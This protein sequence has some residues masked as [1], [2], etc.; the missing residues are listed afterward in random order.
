MYL[1]DSISH[2]TMA[3]SIRLRATLHAIDDDRF[4]CGKCDPA[5]RKSK[6]CETSSQN[7]VHVLEDDL[8]FKRCPGNYFSHE[9]MNFLEM[10]EQFETTGTL[11]YPG[12]LVE[13]PNKIMD[14]F[15]TIACHKNKIKMDRMRKAEMQSRMM[16]RGR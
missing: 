16:K 7:V 1:I 15:R 9:C 13:Q 6:F 5:R 3:E 4:K 14:I 10:H 8:K 11:P 2:L 12:S